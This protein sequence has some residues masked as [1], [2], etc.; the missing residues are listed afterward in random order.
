[1][2]AYVHPHLQAITTLNSHYLLMNVK[3]IIAFSQKI[4]EAGGIAVVPFAFE[5]ALEFSRA[6][7]NHGL[8]RWSSH[9]FANCTRIYRGSLIYCRRLYPL[10]SQAHSHHYH[11]DSSELSSTTTTSKLHGRLHIYSSR[12]S[13]ASK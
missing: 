13:P 5:R 2:S 1:M 10:Y 3:S 8:T 4:S 11:F 12:G 9:D 7:V 6:T